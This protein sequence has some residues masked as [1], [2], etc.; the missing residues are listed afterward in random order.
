MECGVR[1]VGMA[2][3]PRA[4]Y[5]QPTL[6]A[7]KSLIGKVLLRQTDEGP[8]SG[9]IVETEAYLTGDPANHASRGMTNRN[10]T[11]FGPPGH[12]YVYKVHMQCCINA[13][14]Q[15]EGVAEAVLIRALMPLQGI[16]LMRRNRGVDD[17]RALCSGPGKLTRALGI[18][19][20]LD[21]CDLVEGPVL[22]VE[23]DEE[24]GDL[25]LVQT[26]RIGIR[27]AADEPWR[28]YSKAH[29]RWVSRKATRP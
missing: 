3:V 20:S 27:V 10:R 13:V 18:D 8:I 14:A 7:A 12:A 29:E 1:S 24:L 16:E 4:L 2:G 22:I 21:G 9:L 26:T 19:R 11:M 28:F 25:G 17:L 6:D 5:L 23:P 15:P